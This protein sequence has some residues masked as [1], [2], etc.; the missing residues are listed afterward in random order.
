MRTNLFYIGFTAD[1]KKRIFQH[2]HNQ[3]EHT[4][5]RGP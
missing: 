5:N 2:Q 3:S 4:K 1:L